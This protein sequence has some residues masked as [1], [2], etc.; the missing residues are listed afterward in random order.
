MGA[1]EERLNSLASFYMQLNSFH[2]KPLS[3]TQHNGA[4]KILCNTCTCHHNVSS[5]DLIS[6]PV[7]IIT[8]RNHD[9]HEETVQIKYLLLP[10]VCTRLFPHTS[11]P[12]K[13]CIKWSVTQQIKQWSRVLHNK[14]F[15]SYEWKT[16]QKLIISSSVPCL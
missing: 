16:T 13:R 8:I 9:S 11:R 15:Y 14:R 1:K 5:Y 7:D 12:G 10:N 6:I 4:H 3:L 2:A